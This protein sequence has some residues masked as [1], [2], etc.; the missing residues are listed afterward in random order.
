MPHI[1]W[2]EFL[3]ITGVIV[4]VYMAL[5]W[6]M[7]L[8]W[9][10]ENWGQSNF[11]S[12]LLK[13]LY[14]PI[15]VVI[16]IVS[17]ILISPIHHGLIVLVIIIFSWK[18]LKEILTG[19]FIKFSQLYKLDVKYRYGN[20]SGKLTSLD[21]IGGQ[22]KSSEGVQFL[23]YSQMLDNQ[24]FSLVDESSSLDL[25]MTCNKLTST[26]FSIEHIQDMIFDC[27][28]VDH[29]SKPQI[30]KIDEDTIQ[31]DISTRSMI[32]EEKVLK[33]FTKRDEGINFRIKHN[34]I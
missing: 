23:T 16:L 19:A 17:F 29:F 13:H 8:P 1:S 18:Y 12:R 11:V 25:T 22:F 34:S 33:Y 7:I 10:K 2:F 20:N 3:M 4:F 21:M 28:Y 27:P 6:I 24:L 31:F 26:D 14:W 30:K 15:A 9:T 32:Q 5:L